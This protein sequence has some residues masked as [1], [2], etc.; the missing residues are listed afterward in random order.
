MRE[1]KVRHPDGRI[2]YVRHRWVRRR[3]F[4]RLR[5]DWAAQAAN[6]DGPY[7]EREVNPMVLPDAE[8]LLDAA[9]WLDLFGLF[10]VP[11]L[12]VVLLVV[13]VLPLVLLGLVIA[14][15]RHALAWATA[16][17]AA[18]LTVLV[19]VAGCVAL[20]VVRRPWLVVAQRLGTGDEVPRRAWLVTGWRRSRA[21]ARELAAA[22]QDGRFSQDG[23]LLLR[24]DPRSGR[25]RAHPD[26]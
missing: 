9:G 14:G 22:I 4:W 10:S 16:D 21:F 23:V 18:A 5:A 11:G 19:G 25:C 17:P 26:S 7:G 6:P 12:V 15:V 20:L 8:A 13:L 1:V 3:P 24:R 2:W